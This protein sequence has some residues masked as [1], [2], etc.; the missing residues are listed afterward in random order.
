VREAA[1]S[2]SFCYDVF[3]TD[4]SRSYEDFFRENKPRYER[5]LEEIDF[6]IR[7]ALGESGIKVHSCGGRVKDIESALDKIQRKAYSNPQTQMEDV[8]GYRVVCLFVSDLDKL[9]DVVT[10]HFSLLSSENKVEGGLD[11]AT[12]GY[13]SNHYICK[14]KSSY[15]GPRYDAL[16]GIAF[17]IQC[18]TL[19]MDAWANVSHY[20]AYKGTASIP[21]HLRRDFYALSG[22]FYVAD[23][24][25]EL[26]YGEATA[27][28]DVAMAK[29][30]EG[31]A[32]DDSVNLET[33]SALLRQL[34]PDRQQADP[35]SISE[36]VEEIVPLLD[37]TSIK[38]LE[39]DLLEMDQAVR[40]S[41][42]VNPPG[43]KPG[44]KYLDIG[45]AR[46][47]LKLKYNQYGEFLEAKART[48][49]FTTT[50]RAPKA[51]PRR[52]RP[53]A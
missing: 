1:Q 43:T 21:E 37:Y 44:G 16:T 8:V 33:V 20:L 2:R 9:A 24:H 49:F 26:F 47:A 28:A 41:E 50:G 7:Q 13:M 12:F 39:S 51:E 19:L 38:R 31:S 29:A 14:L 52:R 45:M 6:T 46:T 5:L 25:F 4:N 15:S 42:E 34:Y 23:K 11:P 35:A 32:T 40:H 48:D 36:F 18:R 22:L 27:S 10:S 17:E 3:V 30:A 53:T